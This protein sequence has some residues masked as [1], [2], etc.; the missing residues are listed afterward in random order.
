M[1]KETFYITR[2]GLIP[3]TLEIKGEYN[4]NNETLTLTIP[5][6]TYNVNVPANNVNSS[7]EFI[8]LRVD[9]SGFICNENVTVTPNVSIDYYKY[10]YDKVTYEFSHTDI[11]LQTPPPEISSSG[12]KT[13]RSTRLIIRV[14]VIIHS[15][16]IGYGTTLTVKY[17]PLTI[18]LT[19]VKKI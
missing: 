14:F 6:F 4:K 3:S 12:K 1:E 9:L 10:H 8:P 11:I 18:T 7:T 17:E 13:L 15:S 16:E 19:S 2:N 5:S